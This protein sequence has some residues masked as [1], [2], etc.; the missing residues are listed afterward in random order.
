MSEFD[1]TVANEREV[2]LR[3]DRFPVELHEFLRQRIHA[4]VDQLYRR[5]LDTEPFKTGKLKS[6][7]VEREF[8]DNPER[9]AGYVSIYAPSSSNEY[10]KA[11]TLEYG[12]HKPRREFE[13]TNSVTA[14]FGKSRR[15][16]ALRFTKPVHI[17]ARRYLRD[18]LEAMRPA[19][20]AE[21]EHA[22]QEAL[23]AE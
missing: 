6:E 23:D 8:S 15:R 7:T 2:A 21:L 20:L 10:A 19:I 17:E 13:K 9:V 1:V 3:F 4:I 14:R 22:V 18:P 11:A 12:T 16:V 5:I